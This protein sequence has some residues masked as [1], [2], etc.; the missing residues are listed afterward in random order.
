ML[1][2]GLVTIL[3]LAGFGALSSGASGSSVRTAPRNPL[4]PSSLPFNIQVSNTAPEPS[5]EPTVA[6]NRYGTI[7]VVWE[8]QGKLQDPVGPMGMA[9][10]QDDGATFGPQHISQVPGSSFEYDVS[11]AGNSPNGT[12][13][14]GYGVCPVPGQSC[15]LTG[16]V[17]SQDYVTTAW[18]NGSLVSQPQP[19]IAYAQTG[20]NFVDRDWLASTPNGTV[21]QVVDDAS[22]A[23]NDVYL[24]RSFDGIHF[25]APQVIYNNNGIPIDAFAYN[26]TLWG[27]ADSNGSGDCAILLSFDGGSIWSPPVSSPACNTAQSGNIDWQVTWGASHTIDLTF[28]TTTGVDF[29]SSADFGAT[30]STP[31]PV[32]GTTPAGTTFET[33]TIASDPA[34]NETSIIWLD[35]RNN[36]SQGIWYVYEADSYDNGIHWSSPR[37]L[38]DTQ[39]GTNAGG[40]T[41]WPGD[42]IGSTITP[43]GTAAGVWGEDN[44]SGLLQTYFGQLPL[45]RPSAGNL[46]VTVRNSLG[47]VVPNL[48]VS[49]PGLGSARTNASGITTFFTLPPGTYTASATSPAYGSGSASGVVTSGTTTAVTIDL[50]GGTPPPLVTGFT[51]TPSRLTLGNATQLHVSTTGGSPPLTYAYAGLPPGCKTGDVAN[52]NC[53]PSTS[54]NFTVRVVVNDSLSRTANATVLLT[55]LPRSVTPLVIEAFTVNPSVVTPGSMTNLTVNVSGGAQPYTYQYSGLPSGC[56]SANRSTLGCRPSTPGTYLIS[57]LVTDARGSMASK[58]TT[59]AVGTCLYC[60]VPPLSI[61]SF[62]ATPSILSLGGWTNL[63]VSASGGLPP[64]R[65]AY[66]GLPTGCGTANLSTLSCHPTASGS[67]TVRVTVTDATGRSAQA[68]L[69]IT[70]QPASGA[71]GSPLTNLELWVALG[72]VAAA[73][74]VTVLWI[75]RSRR[76]PPAGGKEM[77][78]AS[79]PASW[80]GPPPS[81]P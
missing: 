14:V 4:L 34:T 55:V 45:V 64:Y 43:W 27:V 18:D 1:T 48:P 42:F 78:P 50:S 75:R 62:T 13:W 40:T 72:V 63:S 29:T 24:V 23:T 25:A 46:S 22:G 70:V 57:V 41:F 71:S 31:V 73:V 11:N 38:S 37:Q 32:S 58:N 69:T 39:A 3:F 68:N 30:W 65:Y 56:S 15:S 12:F 20:S 74:V 35:T 53:T 2:V 19:S 26:N 67:F 21:F 76:T 77:A 60:P 10:S 54:G 33:P 9:F 80:V 61:H 49:I 47:S 66:S 51:A 17:T 59:L 8:E 7:Q 44:A 5:G 16:T 36:P 6:V 79:P 52:L 81:D 28:D